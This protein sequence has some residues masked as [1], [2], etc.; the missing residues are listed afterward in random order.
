MRSGF[1]ADVSGRPGGVLIMRVLLIGSAES[2][3][4]E[5]LKFFFEETSAG[6]FQA[7]NAEEAGVLISRFQPDFCFLDVSWLT[8]A[9]IQ[10]L[11]VCCQTDEAFA[12]F[13]MGGARDEK[14]GLIYRGYF[15]SRELEAGFTQKFLEYLKFPERLRVLVADDDEEI[16]GL[17]AEY[18]GRSRKPGFEVLCVRDGAQA[19]DKIA[20]TDFDA[21]LL[22]FSMP[23]KDGREVYAFI[24]SRPHPVPVIVYSDLFSQEQV[25]RLYEIGHPVVV[26]KGGECSSMAHL[27]ALLKKA[28]Y[29]KTPAQRTIEKNQRKVL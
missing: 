27:S 2:G 25:M 29:F 28:A 9:L 19:V 18:L 22:D 10:K 16:R 5:P 7:Q 3:W 20:E 12:L 23:K 26:D 24:Q 6:V 14:S 11:K 17:I 8:P 21:V 4:I 13:Q 1:H 15:S